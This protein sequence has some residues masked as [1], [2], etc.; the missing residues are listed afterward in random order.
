MPGTNRKADPPARALIA[1]ISSF[2]LVLAGVSSWSIYTGTPEA[3]QESTTEAPPP[4][5]RSPTPSET[6]SGESPQDPN[7][8]GKN[9]LD[10]AATADARVELPDGLSIEIP[11]LG[12]TAP[13]NDDV[14]TASLADGV[15]HY[16]ATQIP[17]GTN[18][19]IALAGHRDGSYPVFMHLDSL[20]TCDEITV[21]SADEEWNFRVLPTD[22]Q[23]EESI[24]DCVPREQW[25]PVQRD[26]YAGIPGRSVVDPGATAVINPV[27]G[28]DPSVAPSATLLT[29]TTC[30]PLYSNTERLIVHAVLVDDVDR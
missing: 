29:L 23:P 13:L 7:G 2:L 3:T 30:H 20:K 8:Y 28:Q 18:G 19:N 22:G 12:V 4:E 10:V 5:V 9:V 1:G 6:T 16:P 15:G 27:P 24:Y 14:T 17:G 26:T 25:G 11:S 21:R